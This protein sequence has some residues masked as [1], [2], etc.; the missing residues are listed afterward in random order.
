MNASLRDLEETILVTGNLR[1]AAHDAGFR[2]AIEA[3]VCT[4]HWHSR[5]SWIDS[6]DLLGLFFRVLCYRT[7]RLTGGG[8]QRRSYH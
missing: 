8:G 2:D 7:T 3:L 4:D 6:L 5:G 1:D